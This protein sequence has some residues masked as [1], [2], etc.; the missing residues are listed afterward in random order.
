MR[1]RGISVADLDQTMAS[2]L[3][4]LDGLVDADWQRPAGTLT[5]TCWRTA[6]HLVDVLFSY[7]FQVGA[8]PGTEQLPFQELHADPSASPS[9]LVAGLR[10]AGRLLSAVLAATPS[11]ETIGW[12]GNLLRRQ[13]W[14]AQGAPELLLPNHGITTRAGAALPPPPATAAGAPAPGAAH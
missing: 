2:S 10:S 9:G 13:E 6:E 8:G 7:A 11:D 14:A 1:G 3:T 12:V 5:W 4:A